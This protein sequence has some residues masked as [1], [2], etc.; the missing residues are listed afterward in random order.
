MESSEYSQCPSP[1]SNDV[2]FTIGAVLM[3]MLGCC[4]ETKLSWKILS[5]VKT[6]KMTVTVDNGAID[7]LIVIFKCCR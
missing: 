7:D 5:K 1:S 2:I 6:M 3:L 4:R